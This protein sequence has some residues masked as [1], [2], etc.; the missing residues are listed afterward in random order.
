MIRHDG[1]S[2]NELRKRIGRKEICF[3][4]NTKFKIYGKMNCGS[5]KRM[6]KEHRVFFASPIEAT[7]QGFRPCGHCMKYEHKKWKNGLI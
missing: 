5:G 6:R 3:G 2:D 7:E 4:G 1:L